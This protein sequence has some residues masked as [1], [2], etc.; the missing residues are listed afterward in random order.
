[1]AHARIVGIDIAE[2]RARP[3][4]GRR[5]HRGRPRPRAVPARHLHAAR[6]DA[7]P[8]PRQRRRPLR[9][10]A[11]RRGAS[12]R[13]SA[14]RAK[15]PPSSSSSTTTRCPSSSIPTRRSPGEVLL[16]PEAGTNVCFEIP[17][18]R[19]RLVRRVRGRRRRPD[20]QPEGRALP[21]RGPRRGQPAGSR[22]GRLTHWSSSARAPTRSATAC[23]EV[24]GLPAD[25]VRVITPDVGGGFGAKGFSLP[26][27]AAVPWLARRLGRPVRW[28]ET[29]QR[30]HARARPRPGPGAGRQDRRHAGRQG[31]RLS[32]DGAAGHRRLPADA[33][34]S[35]RS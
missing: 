21:A 22:D 26:R 6:A 34:R 1:M 13:R 28:F 17:G 23:A 31:A 5:V 3:G 25:Q 29:P 8:V 27:G 9:R 10:R 20:Q 11:G 2:A 24:Y 4:R 35:C 33:A 14:T 30:E 12:P 7:P 18:E 16:F 19:R 32:A 15:T